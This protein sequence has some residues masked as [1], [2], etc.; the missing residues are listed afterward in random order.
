[1]TTIS[2]RFPDSPLFLVGFSL[3][4]NLMVKYLGE[5]E[6]AWRVMT[7]TYPNQMTDHA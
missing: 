3:G 7:E 5:K 6:G 1:M 2:G 4:A